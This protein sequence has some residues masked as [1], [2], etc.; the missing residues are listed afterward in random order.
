MEESEID[1]LVSLAKMPALTPATVRSRD[2]L[3]RRILEARQKGYAEESG[4]SV[5]GVECLAVSLARAG[6]RNA[7]IS[8][9]V[10]SQRLDPKKR[11]AIIAALKDLPLKFASDG[12]IL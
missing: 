9:A 6:F 2:E 11:K 8:M 4:E 3:R 10:P 1:A 12:A 7:A 5:E